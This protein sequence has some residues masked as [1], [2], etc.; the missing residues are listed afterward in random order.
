MVRLFFEYLD[1]EQSKNCAF[2]S[3][4][5]YDGTMADEKSL[6][7]KYCGNISHP[8]S[9]TS[10]WNE[11]LVVFQSD[12]SIEKSGFQLKWQEV[13][14]SGH[15]EM[16]C[17]QTR[18]AVI[19]NRNHGTLN[20]PGFNGDTFYEPN[21]ECLWNIIVS[22]DSF[23]KVKFTQLDIEA[24]P[25]GCLHDSLSFSDPN[26]RLPEIRFCG[27][28]T[29]TSEII[30]KGSDLMVGFHSDDSEQHVG[31]RLEWFAVEQPKQHQQHQIY[32]NTISS[33]PNPRLSLGKEQSETIMFDGNFPPIMP[34]TQF[35]QREA[36]ERMARNSATK[37]DTQ[38]GPPS[39]PMVMVPAKAPPQPSPPT[40]KMSSLPRA[41]NSKPS[42]FSTCQ[43]PRRYYY[44]RAGKLSSPGFGLDNYPA[45][46]H[47]SYIITVP[48]GHFVH[49]NFT[50]FEMEYSSN[51]EDDY[52]E[53]FEGDSEQNE[54]ISKIC[55]FQTPG[56][57]FDSIGNRILVVF[58]SNN[59][60]SFKGFQATF[61]AIRLPSKKSFNHFKLQI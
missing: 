2:D 41:A 5:I 61:A 38:F 26:N 28:S 1:L 56:K 19:R 7:G 60:T 45:N 40:L 55:G 54:S 4:S 17:W 52:V 34:F 46:S 10:N 43:T 44:S 15:L 23:I 24:E 33:F 3:L 58:H 53:I 12:N 57:A 39:Q 18:P 35:A 50:L 22:S 48:D 47:C 59:V 30:W 14:L 37:M 51:C 20:L 42:S 11:V 21:M 16:G 29:P 31:F 25:K 8:F 9:V 27:N 13:T 49:L 36:M 32:S 6:H